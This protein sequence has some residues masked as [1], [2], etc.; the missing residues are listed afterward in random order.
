MSQ[1]DFSSESKSRT[2]S[3]ISSIASEPAEV[4]DEIYSQSTGLG[5][6]TKISVPHHINTNIGKWIHVVVVQNETIYN[7]ADV[8]G[9]KIIMPKEH[10]LFIYNPTLDDVVDLATIPLEKLIYQPNNQPV[11]MRIH[12]LCR[13]GDSFGSLACDCGPQLIAAKKSIIANGS[14]VIIYLEQEARNVGLCVKAAL[15]RLGSKGIPTHQTFGYLG[16]EKNDLREYQIVDDMFTAFQI[17]KAEL[18]T[19]NPNKFSLLVKNGRS[20]VQRPISVPANEHNMDYLQT[21]KDH[22]G[23]RSLNPACPTT[24][25]QHIQIA[26]IL[27]ELP[28]VI[29]PQNLNSFQKLVEQERQQTSVA[30]P[31]TVDN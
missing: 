19:N 6:I 9:E 31:M 2:S 3:P 7:P 18:M 26:T 8:A 11:L 29:T 27:H 20:I 13:F 4:L 30:A 5:S 14:G 25:D 21:K 1:F 15:Y 16:F 28:E 12:S 22:M 10:S 24:D 23:H 17:Q